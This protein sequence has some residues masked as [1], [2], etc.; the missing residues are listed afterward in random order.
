MV[1]ARWAVKS[2]GL[3]NTIV[4]AR[5]LV[6]EDFGLIAMAMIVVGLTQMLFSLGVDTALIQNS[7]ADETHYNTAWTI[8][9]IQNVLVG[10]AIFLVAPL[11]AE[12]YA[13]DRVVLL[14]Q[15]LAV[16]VAISGLENIGTVAFRKELQFGNEFKLQLLRKVLS[17]APTIALAMWIRDYWALAYGILLGNVFGVALSYVMHSYR[18]RLSLVRV[19]EIWGYSQWL[20]VV[21]LG[22]YAYTKADQFVIGGTIGSAGLGTYAIAS[23]IAELPSAELIAPISRVV[24][25]G[26]SKI[27]S[28][29]TR[30]KLA[31]LKVHGVI[32]ALAFPA[33]VGL[34][35]TATELVPL[36]MGQK[37]L[38]AIPL[39]QWLALYAGLRAIYGSVGNLAIAQGLMK[40]LALITWLELATLV[41]GA[42]IGG[43]FGGLQ[44][45]AVGKVCV[46]V[47]FGVCYYHFASR[48]SGIRIS[49]TLSTLVRPLLATVIMV[50]GI[51]LV[52]SF[53]LIE[54]ILVVLFIKVV[55]GAA[56]YGSALSLLWRAAGR[57]SGAESELLQLGGRFLR[58][59]GP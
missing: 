4:L 10:A 49:E 12:Y 36:L 23:E 44:G 38:E 20:L 1:L 14:L 33:A 24:V 35:M 39:L 6:P 47:F 21:N 9:I 16:G 18:P 51:L 56:V 54:S 17:V 27:K 30:L 50:G 57:P 43:H 48:L 42:L 5:L 29:P 32:A 22:Y 37:W 41:A 31:Y 34:S 19:S 2:L 8:R 25:P 15:T 11:A 28:D 45:V 55:I 40:P 58:R 59:R 52:Q 46:A 3:L 7:H 26:Y 53:F 13:E